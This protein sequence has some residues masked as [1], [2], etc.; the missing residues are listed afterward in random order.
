VVEADV[1]SLNRLTTCLRRAFAFCAPF[2]AASA[3]GAELV[4]TNVHIVN[5]TPSSF[6]VFFRVNQPTSPGGVPADLA[7][8][9]FADAAG[10]SNL[11]GQLGIE[12]FFLTTGN[13]ASTNAYEYR[14]SR[15]ELRETVRNKGLALMRVSDC[16]PDTNYYFRVSASTNGMGTVTWPG[17]GQLATATT[18]IANSFVVDSRQL[19]VDVPGESVM[20]SVGILQHT[21]AAYPL[22]AVVGDAATDSQMYF[23]LSDLFSA[24]GGTNLI[25]SGEE[26][27][28]IT[29][30]GA[31]GGDTIGRGYALTMDT[32][33]V[34]AQAD[35]LIADATYLYV[36]LGETNVLSDLGGSFVPISV[37]SSPLATNITVLVNIDSSVLTNL[38]ATPQAPE[39]GAATVV[40]LGGDQYRITLDAATGQTIH[41][42]SLQ[43]TTLARL[44][45]DPDPSTLTVLVPL[46][47]T[48]LFLIDETNQLIST[49]IAQDGSVL[50]IGRNPYVE[51]EEFTASMRSINLHGIPGTNYM[52]EFSTNLTVGAW[53]NW[54]EVLMADS[55]LSTVVELPDT[56]EP[57]F[58]IRIREE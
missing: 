38:T 23:N 8:D 27:F 16:L 51:W 6:G 32:N 14:V 31:L 45:F 11:H 44:N 9:V 12:Q 19:V 42:T 26:N 18:A 20:G 41:H 34:V 57:I 37:T 46:D 29:V 21:N 33:T 17:A 55:N 5:V 43:E 53:S 4:V 25:F 10:S 47:I 54:F 40:S 30:Y 28:T 39:V 50:V 56:N 13:P 22:A 15:R 35:G 48:D 52:V 36:D 7:I 49:G 2:L 58:F 1:L 3:A 24:S